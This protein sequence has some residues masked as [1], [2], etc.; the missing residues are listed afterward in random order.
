MNPSGPSHALEKRPESRHSTC[1]RI[2]LI[3]LTVLATQRSKCGLHALKD[4][5]EI[6]TLPLPLIC[7]TTLAGTTPAVISMLALLAAHFRNCGLQGLKDSPDIHA[8]RAHLI[9]LATP[10]RNCAP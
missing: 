1:T 2:R 5:H 6:H 4:S 9:T 7:L 8:W 3:R 10:C